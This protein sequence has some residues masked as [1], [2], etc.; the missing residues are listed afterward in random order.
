MKKLILSVLLVLS[1]LILTASEKDSTKVSFRYD[2]DFQMRFDNRE[3]TKSHDAFTPSRTIFGARLSP[4][5]G[6]GID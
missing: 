4:Y 5:I 6:L 3:Y 1:Y 2:V